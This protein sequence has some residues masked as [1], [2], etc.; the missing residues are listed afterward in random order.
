MNKNHHIDIDLITF[1]RHDIKATI[2]RLHF[3][4]FKREKMEHTCAKL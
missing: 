2:T 1:F 3:Y 4:D